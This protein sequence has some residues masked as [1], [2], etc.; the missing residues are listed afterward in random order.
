GTSGAF[1][2]SLLRA[3]WTPGAAITARI[4]V[5]AVVLTAPALLQLRG[6]WRLLRRN[7]GTVTAYGLIAVAGC[8]LCYFNAVASLSVAVAL[9]LEYLGTVLVVGWLWARRGQRPRRLTVGGAMIA[10]AG[11]ALVLDLT[12]RHRLDG[13]GV[14]WGLG[15]ATGLAVYFVL[16]SSV[17]DP[18]P[19]LV[20]AWGAMSVGGAALIL[21]GVA[22]LL[23]LRAPLTDVD[24]LHH[25][26]SWVVPV[27]GLSLVAAVVAYVAGIRAAR[28]LGAKVASFVGLTEVAFA[29]VLAWLLLGQVPA[30]VQ[31]VGG[32][33][34]VLGVA[35]VRVDELRGVGPASAS[36]RRGEPVADL[37]A[38][39]V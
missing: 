35:L 24:L 5:A 13:V 25:R 7:A 27:L 9:L 1:G 29:V 34:I 6:R 12:G 16:A 36:G 17:D 4:V 14:I 10:L 15:A 28:L 8:Q 32:A 11:L 21:L 38:T 39:S 33:L 2:A 26:L 19:P 37:R 3:G 20:M 18:L 23:P 22:G 30:A 31:F